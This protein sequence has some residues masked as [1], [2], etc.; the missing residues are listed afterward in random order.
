MVH[1][2]CEGARFFCA[3][4]LFVLSFSLE[5]REESGKKCLS[6]LS[7]GTDVVSQMKVTKRKMSFSPEISV[8]ETL[9]VHEKAL[10]RQVLE[11]NPQLKAKDLELALR[12][13]DSRIHEPLST[14][15]SIVIT[16]YNNKM[17]VKSTLDFIEAAQ[18][19][20]DQGQLD[21]LEREHA[22]GPLPNKLS[23]DTVD[24]LYLAVWHNKT[25]GRLDTLNL[26]YNAVLS[27]AKSTVDIKT[28]I[29]VASSL[30]VGP[31]DLLQALIYIQERITVT[32]AS[33]GFNPQGQEVVGPSFFQSLQFF[34]LMSK[35]E[36]LNDEI[37]LQGKINDYQKEHL[38]EIKSFEDVLFLLNSEFPSA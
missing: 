24:L 10:I 26:V 35:N 4:F 17:T 38:H 31:V 32:K 6:A 37:K 13:V 33:F 28:F 16:A 30:R 7:S 36:P 19:A 29:Q 1:V 8:L 14:R 11:E 21:R 3:A 25:K 12:Y 23:I 5:A 18:L 2:R 27:G 20:V 15:L 22:L 34:T 9:T